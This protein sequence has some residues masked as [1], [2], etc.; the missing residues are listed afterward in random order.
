MPVFGLFPA[1][2]R[3]ISKP[4]LK[5]WLN[6]RRVWNVDTKGNQEKNAMGTKM[7]I[8]IPAS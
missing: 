7:S 1:R 5:A 2:I 4:R 3:E 8:P 6:M